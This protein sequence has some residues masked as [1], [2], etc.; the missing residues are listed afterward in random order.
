M[1]LTSGDAEIARLWG[2]SAAA[3]VGS[4]NCLTE[5]ATLKRSNIYRGRNKHARDLQECGMF[6]KTTGLDIEGEMGG[7]S[8]IF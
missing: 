3:E 8:E 7:K 4:W 6:D 5:E 1:I 2:M